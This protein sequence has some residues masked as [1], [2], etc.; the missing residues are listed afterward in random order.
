MSYGTLMNIELLQKVG[1]DL[2]TSDHKN[3]QLHD[4][5]PDEI[6]E[7]DAIIQNAKKKLE[8]PVEPATQCVKQTRFSDRQGNVAERCSDSGVRRQVFTETI[9][10]RSTSADRGFFS[11]HLRGRVTERDFFLSR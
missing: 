5:F 10:V 8:I 2:Q 9:R 11:W 7:F 1:A 4:I 6:E 3:K